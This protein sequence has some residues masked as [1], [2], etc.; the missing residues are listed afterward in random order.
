M[1]KVRKIIARR[2]F[3]GT[4]QLSISK[5]FYSIGHKKSPGKKT[6]EIKSHLWQFKTSSKIDFW[7][8][9]KLQKMELIY[10]ISRVLW[11]GLFKIFWPIF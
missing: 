9:L 6:R 3:C 7:P 5:L 1:K 8:F 2:I 4:C 11:P 10:L